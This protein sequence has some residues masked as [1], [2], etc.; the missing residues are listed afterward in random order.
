MGH[1]TN[2]SNAARRIEETHSRRVKVLRR[3]LEKF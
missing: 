1:Y 2:A 3:K